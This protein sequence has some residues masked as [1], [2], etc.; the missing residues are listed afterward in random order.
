[1]FNSQMSCGLWRN[2]P[3]LMLKKFDLT[4]NCLKIQQLY[5]VGT[6]TCHK[7]FSARQFVELTMSCGLWRNNAG[8]LSKKFELTEDGLERTFATNHLGKLS[9]S[10]WFH[11]WAR[12]WAVAK[13]VY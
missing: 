3:G 11:L 12:T 9:S 6:C 4:G 10:S 1:L 13:I 5:S 8:L 7:S 2:N